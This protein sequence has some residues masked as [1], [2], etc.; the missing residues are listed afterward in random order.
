MNERLKAALNK[1]GSNNILPF[2]WAI[3]G[4]D[5]K[6]IVGQ[7][8]IIRS[9][10]IRSV[11]VES[12]TFE[13]FAGDTWWP[14]IEEILKEAKRL[15]MR[16]WI[17]DDTHFPTGYAAGWIAKKYPE[18]RRLHLAEFHVDV[19]GPRRTEIRMCPFSKEDELLAVVAVKRTGKDEELLPET[20]IVDAKKEDA[21]CS[22][23]APS[24]AWRVFQLWL[25]HEGSSSDKPYIN[26][27]DPES[28]QV[29]VDAVYEAHYE[30]VGAYFGKELAGFF[31]DEPCFGNNFITKRITATH[32]HNHN[33]SVGMPGLAMPWRKG[34]EAVLGE[35]TGRSSEEIIRMLPLLWF[36]GEGKSEMRVCYMDTVS[37]LYGK[38]FAGRLGGWCRAHNVEYI[39]HVIE[40]NGGHC[41]LGGSP[42]HYFRSMEGQDMAGLDVVLTQILPGFVHT[43]HS[44]SLSTKRVEPL[45]YSFMLPKLGPSLA[46]IRP[47]MKNRTM[48]EVF[49]AYGWALDTP[50]MKYLVDH[51]LVFG[52]T[53]FVP[54]AFSPLY[55]YEDCPPHF[56]GGGENPQFDDFSHLMHYLGK[57]T[58]LLEGNRAVKAAVLYHAE[59]EWSGERFIT[60]DEVSRVLTEAQIDFDIVP[61]EDLRDAKVENGLWRDGNGEFRLLV[62]PGAE[63]L[64]D[65]VIRDINRLMDEGL[66][67]VQAEIG[68][69]G[70]N[71][72]VL[73]LSELVPFAEKAGVRD[74]IPEKEEIYL[75][76][77]HVK[78]ADSDVFMFF[79]ESATDAIDTRIQLPVTGKY[80]RMDILGG[81]TD[82]ADALDGCVS[83]CLSPYESVVY[84]FD[85]TDAPEAKEEKLAEEELDVLWDISVARCENMTE[86]RVLDRNVPLRT[87]EKELP[88][89]AGRI[90][91]TAKI[92]N[93]SG[94]RRIALENVGDTACV[95]VN[96]KPAGRRI[97]APF[98]FDTDGL[99]GEGTNEISIVVSTTLARKHWDVFSNYIAMNPMGLDGR[100]KIFR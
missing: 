40:D 74:I 25:T 20:I 12:R 95:T 43:D 61:A 72:E 56:Y 62:V 83:V 92:E 63:Y 39:G 29:L 27:I 3:T 5:T 68:T 94:I 23:T 100:V 67:V 8:E 93:G 50:M 44:A 51:F 7:M 47:H 38:H 71:A 45:F 86:Y 76:A 99:F 16:V 15:D 77:L 13:D 79:N 31:S 17:L 36:D 24:G 64:P 80:T 30:H 18:R 19:I 73:A 52:T 46:H 33:K 41:R 35:K 22:F 65:A 81:K 48:C 32:T 84:V 85:G 21:Y 11:C 6:D 57:M 59:M 90:C 10:G 70:L 34:L 75:R 78:H 2:M 58:A 89:F 91:Y 42:G 60:N 54:H 49:G 26:M 97:C 55:P 87:I 28:V 53:H 82:G 98:V 66:T 14:L 37:A 88:D 96:G 4:I 69:K 9:C 1:E